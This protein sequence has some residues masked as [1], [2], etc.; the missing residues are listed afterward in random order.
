MKAE[1]G[2]STKILR[3]ATPADFARVAQLI[4]A[5]QPEPVTEARHQQRLPKRAHAGH[6]SQAGLRPSSWHLPLAQAGL[7]GKTAQLMQ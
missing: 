7:K 4:S 1:A 6:Q 2:N 3:E 5:T